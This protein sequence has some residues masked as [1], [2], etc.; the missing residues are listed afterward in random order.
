MREAGSRRRRL[1][2]LTLGIDKS[3]DNNPIQS[4][5]ILSRQFPN[6]Q[7]IKLK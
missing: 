1:G 2:M 6:R 7:A 4:D 5:W 3:Q